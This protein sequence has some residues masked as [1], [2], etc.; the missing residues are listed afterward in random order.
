M[1]VESKGKIMLQY[2][3]EVKC[4]QGFTKRIRYKAYN[5][6]VELKWVYISGL[7]GSK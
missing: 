4:E 5:V 3:R 6:L 1:G 7:M 2:I